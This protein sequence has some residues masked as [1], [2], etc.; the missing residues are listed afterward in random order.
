MSDLAEASFSK[1]GPTADG[2]CQ[3][4]WIQALALVERDELPSELHGV[5]DPSTCA[6]I[7]GVIHIAEQASVGVHLTKPTVV[8]VATEPRYRTGELDSTTGQSLLQLIQVVGNAGTVVDHHD[9]L[10]GLPF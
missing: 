8:G 5:C 2:N 4:F 3:A 10:V 1:V 9:G 6:G 7:I